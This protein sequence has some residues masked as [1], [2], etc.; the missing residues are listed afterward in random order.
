MWPFSGGANETEDAEWRVEP[1]WPVAS[2]PVIAVLPF[3]N[4]SGDPEQEYFADGITEDIITRLTRY[5]GLGVIARNT[6]FQYKGEAVDARAVGEAL[7]ARFV[8][9]GSVRRGGD[10]VRISAQL[11]QVSN[12]TNLWAKAFDRSLA[13]ADIFAIQDEISI[14]VAN[15]LADQHGVITI[16]DLR[17]IV[18][19]P[20]ASLTAYECKLRAVHYV[21]NMSLE[22]LEPARACLVAVTR[23]EPDYADAWALRSEINSDAHATWA[24]LDRDAL[25]ESVEFANRAIKLEPENQYAHWALAYAY[26]LLGE[27]DQFIEEAETAESL[28]PFHSAV[29]GPLGAFMATAGEWER[30]YD[31]MSRSIDVNPHYPGWIN[32]VLVSYHIR[33]GDLD[34]AL[35]RSRDFIAKLPDFYWAY[36]YNAAVLGLL[37]RP[38]EAAISLEKA[39][40]LQPSLATDTR[41]Q[42][43][44]WYYET[45]PI[46]PLIAGL[47]KAGLDVPDAPVQ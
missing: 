9:E 39:L 5:G 34:Q 38:D 19:R 1:E 26:F 29:V 33:A 44:T 17:E 14:A 8:L 41:A 40:R 4:M 23:D 22:T 31:W 24:L 2:R 47:R 30:G 16:S 36:T 11:M 42:L 43:A 18:D 20:A 21:L 25:N 13:A 27:K 35:A 6:M 46:E 45:E 28:N 37:D 12:G 15:A 10:T 32:Y 3:T 7:G